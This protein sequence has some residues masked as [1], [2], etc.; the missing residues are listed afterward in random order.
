M[1]FSDQIGAQAYGRP[2]PEG[3][4]PESRPEITMSEDLKYDKCQTC[5]FYGDKKN[6]YENPDYCICGALCIGD[7]DEYRKSNKKVI[8]KSSQSFDSLIMECQDTLSIE[9][10]IEKKYRKWTGVSNKIKVGKGKIWLM[11]AYSTAWIL[12]SGASGVL[13]SRGVEVSFLNAQGFIIGVMSIF[14]G[15]SSVIWFNKLLGIIK[16]ENI[17]KQAKELLKNKPHKNPLEA[18]KFQFAKEGYKSTK[19]NLNF[20]LDKVQKVVRDRIEAHQKDRSDILEFSD[21]LGDTEQATNRIDE[22]IKGLESDHKRLSE[23]Q[24]EINKVIDGYI[25]ESG[26]LSQKEKDLAR[27]LKAQEISSKMEENFKITMEVRNGVDILTDVLIPGLKQIM[28]FRI[29]ELIEDITMQTDK[30]R[31]FL[32]IS[33]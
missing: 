22:E 4:A 17:I 11:F 21:M 6:R 33:E 32:E 18:S 2:E 25:G 14:S 9:E 27:A 31:A 1:T 19:D 13:F 23:T 8:A 10:E 3:K 7:G 26:I 29:P 12:L 30:E 28:A 15:G 24:K 20:T 16:S 5:K